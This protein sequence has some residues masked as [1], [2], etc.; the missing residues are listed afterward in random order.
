MNFTG[1]RFIPG[2]GGSQIAYEHL[3]RYLFALRWADGKQVLDLACGS[4]YG[5]ALL[6]R[7]ARH[8]WAIDLDTN[9]VRGASRDWRIDNVSFVQGD[10]TRLPFRDGSM[11]LIVVM[12]TLEHI[13]D[14]ERLVG[15][16][17]RVCSSNSSVLISTPNKAIYSDA[18]QYVNPFH[19]RELYLEEFVNLLRRHFPHVQIAGQQIRAGSL[20]SC[21]TPEPLCEVLTEPAPSRE[22]PETEPMYF[23]AV[24]SMEKLRIPV[25]AHS[26]YLDS[27]DSL[28]DEMKQEINRLN[29]EIG[30]LG[31]WAKNL[32]DA[33]GERNQAIRELQEKMTEEVGLRD[34][35]I[36]DIQEKM[37]EEVG[38]R[39]Q[40]IRDLQGKMTE[41]VALRDQTILDLRNEMEAEITDRD[42]RIVDALNLL[43][44]KE[45][46]F[47]ER[48][49]WA[50]SLQAEV[51]HLTQI[52]HALLYRLLSR[53]GLIPK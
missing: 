47:D 29:R 50:L 19:I 9:A 36:R 5:A 22:K 20:L 10:A 8:V 42:Q 44:Q 13:R 14:Q 11:E 43:H 33:I 34:Q 32:E 3:H 48:G 4:G 28:I 31:R 53:L 35:A 51:E 45:R 52:R 18:R 24:C 16:M 39:D 37:T 6:A 41:A 40:A 30:G 21:N 26:A 49:Q 1:E 7:R 46:E 25:P 38:L 15:E 27:T 23:V 12:E 17:A 2:Q